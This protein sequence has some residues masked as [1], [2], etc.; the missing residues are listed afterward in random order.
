MRIGV[1]TFGG[2]GG[3]SGISRYIISLLEH[4]DRIAPPHEV[5]VVV[6]ESERD[7]FIPAGSKT[8]APVVMPES[9]KPPVRNIWWHQATLP[10][11]ARRRGHDVLFLPAA[12]R[13]TCLR[14][15]CPMVGTMHDFSSVHVAGKYDPGR[16]F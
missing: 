13:R 5:E 14:A 9:L 15:P 4:L 16:M 1:C 11:L 3:K 10:G 2:D 6:Y 8:L 7:V 12:N